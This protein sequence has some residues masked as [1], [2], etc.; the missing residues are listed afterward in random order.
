[1]KEPGNLKKQTEAVRRK[2]RDVTMAYWYLH[3]ISEMKNFGCYYKNYSI[4][5]FNEDKFSL[6]HH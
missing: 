3:M 5:T 4:R 6:F 2:L 1:M